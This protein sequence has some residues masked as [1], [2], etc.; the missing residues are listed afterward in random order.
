M[1]NAILAITNAMMM[2]YTI[3]TS[4]LSVAASRIDEIGLAEGVTMSRPVESVCI[5]TNVTHWN[6]EVR[7]PHGLSWT[8]GQLQPGSVVKEMTEKTET[9]EVVKVKTLKF[10]WDGEAY[11]AKRERVLSRNVK[12]WTRKDN[13]VEE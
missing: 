4:G 3:N 5:M 6:N 7:H 10:S 1:T 9:T 11:T 2:G 12:R 8:V 13:W